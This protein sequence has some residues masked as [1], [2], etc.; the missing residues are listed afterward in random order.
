M[1]K[2]IKEDS[3][4]GFQ[5]VRKGVRDFIQRSLEEAESFRT[6]LEIRKKEKEFDDM[7]LRLG[8]MLFERLQS[9]NDDLNDPD[10]RNLFSRTFQIKEDLENLKIDLA[11]KFDH[12]S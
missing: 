7:A 10:L 11:E 5:I 9:G 12:A 8:K 3:E 1:L 2:R 6:R 4:M